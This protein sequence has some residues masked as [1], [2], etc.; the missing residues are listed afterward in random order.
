MFSKD[1]ALFSANSANSNKQF[2]ELDIQKLHSLFSEQQDLYLLRFTL[3]I[4]KHI[5]TH[6][7]ETI[8]V[9]QIHLQKCYIPI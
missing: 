4:V 2:S 7:I 8:S 1:E 9:Q 3:K 5:F 6:E